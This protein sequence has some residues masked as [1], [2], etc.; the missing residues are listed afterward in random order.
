MRI[1]NRRL[2]YAVFFV[3]AFALFAAV[4]GCS[5][6]DEDDDDTLGGDGGGGD[7]DD[8]GSGECDVEPICSAFSNDG[9]EGGFV[10]AEISNDGDYAI[11]TSNGFA[12]YPM[13]P[14]DIGPG[15][16]VEQDHEFWI[17]LDPTPQDTETPLGPVGVMTNG[18]PIFN[19]WDAVELAGCRNNA[20]FVRADSFDQYEGHPEQTGAYHHHTGGV[21]LAPGDTGYAFNA[22]AHSP[23]LAYAFDGF[24][25]YG[26][27]GY[28]DGNDAGSG[29]RVLTT[30][31]ELKA[32][33]DCCLDEDMCGTDAQFE[34][35]TLSLGA[36]LDD[37]E[38]D[39]GHYQGGQCDLNEYNMRFQKTPEYPDGVWAYVATIEDGKTVY[40]FLFGMTY[41]GDAWEDPDAGGPPGK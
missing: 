14:F 15:D 1:L 13:G 10:S 36:F 21:F 39:N 5:C 23:I 8:A 7:D 40:P 41:Y 26:P 25:V 4:G 32:K 9:S 35:T 24:P 12:N 17:P 31:Y 11:V 16:V 30:C 22:D 2:M 38:F 20:K 33:R 34:G 27:Y 3:A 37:Y 29:I 19:P 28:D 6:S 18:I